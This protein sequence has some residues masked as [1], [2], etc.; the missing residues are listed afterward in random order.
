MKTKLARVAARHAHILK[1]DIFR[2]D[3]HPIDLPEAILALCA[4]V[5]EVDETEHLWETIG[6]HSEAC[7]GD[8]IVGAFWTFTEWHAGQSSPEYAAL[9]ALGRIYSPG[10]TSGP[11]PESGEAAAAEMLGAWFE[12]RHAF[13]VTLTSDLGH[14]EAQAAT[15][16]RLTTRPAWSLNP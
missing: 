4:A 6:E 15:L 13:P 7:L 8:L 14:A 16:A 2:I 10:M 9:C 3:G 12:A 1:S 11:E 5:D